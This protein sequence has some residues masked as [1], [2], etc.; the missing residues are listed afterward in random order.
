V[1]PRRILKPTEKMPILFL[2]M[3]SSAM[4][5]MAPARGHM[6]PARTPPAIWRSANIRCASASTAELKRQLL[7]SA[8][9]FKA[10]QEAR[11]EEEKEEAKSSILNAESVANIQSDTKCTALR[12]QTIELINQL[13]AENPS[14]APFADWKSANVPKG[15]GLDGTWELQFT[16]GAD[17]TFRKTEKSGAAKTY[18]EIDASKGMFVNCVDFDSP[19]AKLKGFRVYVAGKKLSDTEV[20]LKFRAVKL[21]RRSR[22]LKSVVI[23]LPPSW[24]LRGVAKLASRGKA[25]LSDRG[26]GFQMLYLDEDLRMHKTFDGQYFVQSRSGASA[27]PPGQ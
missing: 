19:D 13:A 12:E 16:T 26:A 14:G 17:A 3:A 7:A 1:T 15:T 24:L 18:Q 25:K 10:A 8:A 27:T 6:A 20:Q 5:H 22:L 2:A 9:A 23:P 21:L 4:V 11:W